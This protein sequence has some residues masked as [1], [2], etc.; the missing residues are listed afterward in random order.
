[1]LG[2]P[3]KEMHEIKHRISVS[4]PYWLVQH[5]KDNED[6]ISVYVEQALVK[7]I[8]SDKKSKQK[9]KAA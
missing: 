9:R 2:R 5:L 6:N 3:P 1:M 8:K 7:K 4:L